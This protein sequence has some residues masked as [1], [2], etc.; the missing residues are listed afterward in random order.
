MLRKLSMLLAVIV[1]FSLLF[2]A[3]APTTIQNTETTAANKDS[4]TQAS[5]SKAGE[6]TSVA[7]TQ[8]H[9]M[10]HWITEQ[11]PDKINE[12]KKDFEAKNP[13]IELIFDDIPF[14]QQHDKVLA[15]H[16]AGTTPDIF[17]VTGA[18]I[19]EFADAGIIDPLDDYIKK[20]PQDFKD[21]LQG[22]MFLPWKGKIYGMPVTNGNTALFYNKKILAE[23]NVQPP[24]TWDEFILACKKVTDVNKSR[25]A[26][27]G[28]IVADP[29]TALSYEVFP[30][31]LQ[32]GGKI[33]ENSRAAFNTAEGVKA[34]ELFKALIKEYKVTTPGELNAGEKEKRANFSAGNVAFMFEGPWGVA[35]QKKANPDLEFSVVPLPKGKVTGTIVQGSCLGI[36]SKA[37][38]KDAAWKFLEYMGSADGQLLWDKATNF[39]PYNKVTM[40]D[41]FFKNDQYLK[42]FI[43]QHNNNENNQV[44]DNFLPQAVDLRRQFT[45]E[46]QNFLTGKKTAQKALD[47]AA[48]YWNAAFEKAGI[49]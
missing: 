27:T 43:D 11:G 26:L 46:V 6:T 3:C 41:E 38:N 8:I 5:Q 24:T 28:N 36:S 49:K 14:V 44:I 48:A 15:L 12:V 40:Q 25:Y 42:V 23:A 32:A 21:A 30:F 22:P 39:F 31:I 16:M 2:A 17:T 45:N 1:V 35:I 13:S 37:K 34:L 19:T 10:Q 33:I 7:K 20:L 18:W 29:P 9:W 4:Q 47:D